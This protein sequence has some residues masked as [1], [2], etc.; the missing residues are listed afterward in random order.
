MCEEGE[1]TCDEQTT[2]TALANPCH[3]HW[4]GYYLRYIYG[5]IYS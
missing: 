3:A 4:F 1:H 5:Q 2:T